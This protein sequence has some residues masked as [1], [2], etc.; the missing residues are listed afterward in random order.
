MNPL[1]IKY[2]LMALAFVGWTTGVY[3]Y[4]ANHTDLKWKAAYAA[5][6]VEAGK[7]LSTALQRVR[8]KEN[9]DAES[10]LKIDQDHATELRSIADSRDDF[11]SK[12]R[13][14]RRGAS[15]RNNPSPKTADPGKPSGAT[16]I[17]DVGLGQALAVDPG[18]QARDG[19]RELV[20][21]TKAC[22]DFALKVGR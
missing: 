2:G 9:A 1:A 16:E 22:H 17:S 10:A 5:Q 13:D 6:A 15:C 20:A 21:F 3:F 8:D 7:V 18:I 12:L 19:V 14:A 11:A 4:S